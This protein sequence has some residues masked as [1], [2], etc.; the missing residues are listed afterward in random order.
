M[1]ERRIKIGVHMGL[2]IVLEMLTT[3]GLRNAIGGECKWLMAKERRDNL[4]PWQIEKLNEAMWSIAE[5]L[6]ETLIR[7][8]DERQSV[9]DQ[10]KN[11]LKPVKTNYVYERCMKHDTRWWT[12]RTRALHG[13]GYGYSFTEQEVFQ[14]NLAVKEIS[15]RLLSMEL[16]P[17]DLDDTEE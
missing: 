4:K 7:Y 12:Y 17:D 13:N 9:I 3:I 1:R 6:S 10:V 14:I 16:V 5:T 2:P 8:S 15:S 11:A